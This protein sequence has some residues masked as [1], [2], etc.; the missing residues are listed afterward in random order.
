MGVRHI[1]N[2][3]RKIYESFYGPVPEGYHIHHKDFDPNNNDPKN[4]IAVSP[5][6]HAKIHLNAGHSWAINGKFIQGASDA[7]KRGGKAMLESLSDSDRKKWHSKGGKSSRNPGGYSMKESGKINIKN[8]RLN[9]RKK[10]CPICSKLKKP[11][12]KGLPMDGGNL[13]KHMKLYHAD[14]KVD[15]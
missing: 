7:G 15:N 6:E 8:A 9:S 11:F 12:G 3:Y 10:M 2:P 13:K 1:N 5:Q 4:L 14:A